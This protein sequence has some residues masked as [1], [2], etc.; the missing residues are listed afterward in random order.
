MPKI[1]SWLALQASVK[2]N[3]NFSFIA[4]DIC[5]DIC[6]LSYSIDLKMFCAMKTLTEFTN[7]VFECPLGQF[8]LNPAKKDSITISFKLQN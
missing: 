2:A 8:L 4:F 6:S 5:A 3:H 1:F 7:N